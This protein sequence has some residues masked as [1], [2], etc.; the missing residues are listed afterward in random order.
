MGRQ[1]D[2]HY[3]DSL[4]S[5][6]EVRLRLEGGGPLGHTGF[7]FLIAMIEGLVVE[8][9]TILIDAGP[10]AD[11]PATRHVGSRSPP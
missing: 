1:V 9:W 5:D 10:G 4:V 6:A 3:G 11:D 7:Q 2:D 8:L